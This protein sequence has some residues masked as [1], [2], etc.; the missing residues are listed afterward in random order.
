MSHGSK[1]H[2]SMGSIGPG[3]TP[4][5]TFKGLHMPGQMG[6]VTATVRHL[7][8]VSVD[9]EKRLMLIRGTVPGAEGGLLVIT[10]SVTKWNAK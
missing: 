4:G 10:P 1:F 3:T 9:T 6:N 8:V 7:T 5:R 2:R